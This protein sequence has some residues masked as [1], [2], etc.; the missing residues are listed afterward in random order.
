MK[1]EGKTAA[2]TGGSRGIGRAI[3]EKL[4]SLGA[5]V[6]LIYAGN[7]EAAAN[8]AAACAEKYGVRVVTYKCDVSDFGAVKETSAKIKSELGNVTILVNNA[9][10]TR[11]GILPMMK[12][13]DFDDVIGT[14]LKGAFNMMKNMCGMMIRAREGRIVNI[15]SV[16]GI[17]GNAG[18]ANYSASKAGIIGLTKSAAREL[19]PK[20]ITCNAIAPG[21]VKT[22]MTSG[23]DAESN[24]LLS[25]IPLGRMGTP[26]EIA[27][28]A[29]FL[30]SSD[31]ITGEGL[32]VDGG[33]AM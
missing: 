18:Q 5:N 25:S 2:V 32:R 9:G 14:N 20:N 19:A 10:I 16:S 33:I 17:I 27:D 28:A 4:C 24:A 1:I 30:I 6:A 31:Y 7:D 23:I 26:E 15:S 11:D 22:D 21:F 13:S 12:E 8:V 29:A 3:V